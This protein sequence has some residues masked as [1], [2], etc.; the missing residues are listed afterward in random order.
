MKEDDEVGHGDEIAHSEEQQQQQTVIEGDMVEE[1]APVEEANET[2]AVRHSEDE[3]GD[4]DMI[5]EDPVKI[6]KLNEKIAK[7]FKRTS[8]D[9]RNACA[10]CGLVYVV[11]KP[12]KDKQQVS[13]VCV[14]GDRYIRVF[15]SSSSFVN[16]SFMT[17]DQ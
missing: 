12:R 4:D 17:N 6:K 2:E 7:N 11:R 10:R 15:A 3:D 5:E 16:F 14:V 1:S 8:D 13:K 9:D